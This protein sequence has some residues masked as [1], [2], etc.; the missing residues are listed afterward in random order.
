MEKLR[1]GGML[2]IEDDTND[3]LLL[4]RAFKR[5]NFTIPF[6]IVTDGDEAIS[7]L[8]GEGC[9][10]DRLTY[11]YPSLILLDLKLPKRSGLE[12]LTWLKTQPLLRRIPV[13]VL[14]SSQENQDVDQAY[15]AGAS[16][17]LIKPVTFS[18]LESTISVLNQYWIDINHYSNIPFPGRIQVLREDLPIRKK[19]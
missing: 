19:G 10:S 4:R 2:I 5:A 1:A 18:E 17:Y 9:Y 11:P 16:S 8:I 14:T 12:V 15:E 6:N 13:I 3:I 7:Y